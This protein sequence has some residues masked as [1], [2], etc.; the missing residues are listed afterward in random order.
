VHSPLRMARPKMIVSNEFPYHITGRSNNKEWFYLPKSVCWEIFLEIL[1]KTIEK[2]QLQ[3]LAFVLLDNHYHMLVCTPGAN[4]GECMQYFA[5][6]VSK[7]MGLESGRINRIFGAR[8]QR[9]LIQNEF[10]F[11]NAVKYVFRNP[12]EAGLCAKVEEYPFSTLQWEISG[13]APLPLHRAPSY[14]FDL[15]PRT[16]E[17]RLEWFNEPFSSKQREIIRL[18]LRK[19]VFSWPKAKRYRKT[20]IE[21][22]PKGSDR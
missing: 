4:I 8:Y 9:T 14:M 20:V 17:R 6:E 7:R 15:L 21:L 5:R 1:G 18:G 16:L 2:Y 22:D 12:V 3:L 10:Y 13:R 11:M 19:Q